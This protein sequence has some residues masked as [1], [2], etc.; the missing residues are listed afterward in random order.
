MSL[1]KTD[2]IIAVVGVVILIVAVFGI[3]FYYEAE[4]A[5][6]EDDDG[7]VTKEFEVYWTDYTVE[8][9]IKGRAEKNSPYTDPI[10]IS[11]DEGCV[12]SIVEIRIDWFD[13]YTK[14]LIIN[15][16]EDTLTAKFTPEN[17]EMKRHSAKKSGNQ[18]FNF[19]INT[20]IPQNEIIK[21][22]EDIFA[23]EDKIEEDYAGVSSTHFEV[24]ITVDPGENFLTL[25]PIKF[26]NFL[27]DKGNGFDLFVTYKYYK[28]D[29]IE[30]QSGNSD[31]NPV[32]N[33]TN[34]YTGAGVYTSTNYA[35]SKL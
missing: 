20:I 21:D 22:V 23:A 34:G 12:L 17:G 6:D 1:K 29:I 26:L 32:D 31:G 10:D 18:T 11:L 7:K 8:E 4:D 3:L 24:E 2:K 33:N 25:R 9:K 16:G 35:L 13:D 30:I 19:P 14:G 28:P 27:R 15:K 5:A